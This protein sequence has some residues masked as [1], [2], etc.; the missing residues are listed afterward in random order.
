MTN[1]HVSSP[2]ARRQRKL[3]TRPHGCDAWLAQAVADRPSECD[4]RSEGGSRGKG[5]GPWVPGLRESLDEITEA[6]VARGDREVVKTFNSH[7]LLG[8]QMARTGAVVIGVGADVTPVPAW[9]RYIIYTW[10]ELALERVVQAETAS[11]LCVDGYDVRPPMAIRPTAERLAVLLPGGTMLRNGVRVT[12]RSEA[13]RLHLQPGQRYLL[14]GRRCGQRFEPWYGREGVFAIGE[15][16]RLRT[17][18]SEPTMFTEE[19]E[20]LGSLTRVLARLKGDPEA[21]EAPRP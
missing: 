5:G 2:P 16:E 17:Q 19:V 3:N 8:W 11:S 21:S 12:Y 18:S 6:A 13:D 1:Q 20:T 14:F 15:G 4:A 7:V 10:Y 9:E